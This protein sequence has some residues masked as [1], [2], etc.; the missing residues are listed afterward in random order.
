MEIYRIIPVS[1]DAEIDEEFKEG[2]YFEDKETAEVV[3]TALDALTPEGLPKIKWSCDV[4]DVL[5]RKQALSDFA[6]VFKEKL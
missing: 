5:S 1:S 4:I 3:M 6:S 2:F